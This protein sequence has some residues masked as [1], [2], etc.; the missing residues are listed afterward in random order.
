MKK[1][2][3]LS[4][5]TAAL[6]L[7][8]VSSIRHANVEKEEMN[9][10]IIVRLKSGV[11]N[12][13]S[14]VVI[15]EQNA[16]ISQIREYVTTS[17]EVGER[18]TSLVNA[19]T[20]KVPA[21]RVSQIK[22]LPAVKHVDYNVMHDVKYM[23][24]ELVRVNRSS[25]HVDTEKTNIS[26]G[27]MNK[28]EGT[29]D[30][31][32]VLIAIL[33]TGYL[34][35]GKLYDET[36]KTVLQ[37][38]VTHKAY[39]ALADDVKLHDTEESINAK[40]AAD[41]G[42]HGK[43][44]ATHSVY[45][46][47]KVP[48]FYDYGGTVTEIGKTAEDYDVFEQNQEHGN[49]VASTAAGNDPLYK[50]IAPKAQLAL[51]KVF[52]H[53][54]PTLKDIADGESESFGAYDEAI[55]KA[56]EDCKTLGV[57]IISMSLGSSLDDFDSDSTVQTALKALQ[58]GGTFVN[59][60]AGNDGK[61]TFNGSPYEYWT[62][63][64]A[65][66]G[67]LS[68][69]SNNEGAMTI[70]AAQADKE[71]YESAFLVDGHMV[72]YRDQI[73][74][75]EGKDADYKVERRLTDL[76]EGGQDSFAWEKIPNLG[77][78][79][80]Y[81]GIDVN[82]KIA[83]VDRGEL[84]FAEKIS[85]ATSKGAIAV[86]IIDND[87]TN[88]N[89]NV[90]MALSGANPTVPVI[91]LLY[92]D[93]DI[94]V[95]AVNHTS[96]VIANE[97]ADNPTARKMTD[98]SSDGPTYD[99][100]LKPEISAPGQSILGGV[101]DG[102]DSYEY[103]DGTSMATPNFSGAMA[104][105]LSKDPANAEYRQSI[106]NRIMSTADPMVEVDNNK[107]FASV[108]RQGAGMV[109]INGAL[110]SEVYLDGAT[111]ST[112][113][114]KA[115]I[116]LGNSEKIKNGTVALSFTSVNEGEAVEYSATTYVYRPDITQVNKER[117]SDVMGV[118]L[119]AIYNKQIAKVTNNVTVA[120]G[121][122][123]VSLPD[124]AIPQDELTAINAKFE[125]GCYIEGF[126]ILEA[127]GKETINI[128]FLGYYGDLSALSPVEPFKFERDNTKVYASDILN[129][130]VREWGGSTEADF[131]SDWVSGYYSSFNAIDTSSYLL[132]EKA[133]TDLTG[134][135]TKKLQQVG[136]NPYNGEVSPDDIYMGNNGASNTMI[137]SQFV[138]R[139]VANNTITLKNKATNKT[140]LT[141]H[142][143]DA[144]FGA[145]EDENEVEYQWP[146]YK[147]H[148]VAQQLWSNKLYAHRAYTIIPLYDNIYDKNAKEGEQYSVGELFPDG[149]YEM[150]F[151]YSLT[152]GTVFTKTYTLH[153]DSKAPQI[154]SREKVT[155]D[156]TDYLRFYFDEEKLG[157]ISVN[158]VRKA[159]KQDENGYY[160]DVKISDYAE[161][162]KLLIKSYDY[163]GAVTTSLTYVNDV[164]QII[165]SN[166]NLV[167]SMEFNA[168]LVNGNGELTLS[169][170]I[171]KDGKEAKL[172]GPISV[173]FKLPEGVE[174]D[175]SKF[176]I[177]LPDGK[178][179]DGEVCNGYVTLVLPEGV[180]SVTVKYADPKETPEE[181]AK[182]KGCG[183]SLIAGSAILSI[184]AALGASLLLFKKRKED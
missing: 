79:E 110:T 150:K 77:A 85:N 71:F 120:A 31:E 34:L 156:G 155:V 109:D 53:Y 39:T 13:N 143:Y 69:Y 26:A 42:F 20:L 76:L 100:R 2:A 171:L 28:P 19:F 8:G 16:V 67:I 121:T 14:D 7:G 27:T 25:I 178:D 137:I 35:D 24:P 113:S 175:V 9:A 86:G 6:A 43:P 102:E 144:L 33:D 130:T 93:R 64:M 50:G 45:W 41:K 88:T 136:L 47:N 122:N 37:E 89:F 95:N 138:L 111:G 70:A 51:M 142:M 29:K 82:G 125:S 151:S 107:I 18:F 124:L 112:L 1:L 108:R 149:E 73:V 46:N 99:L 98:F 162:N 106:N 17:I 92:K 181:P 134:S 141:D 10:N 167:G 166:D 160:Y 174:V 129:S 55:L 117:F 44:D 40:I 11:G 21:G 104:V 87:P 131:A 30:G 119:Q 103:M 126:V 164:N 54:T 158:S 128:P 169:L 60:A 177:T 139:S 182:K 3:L 148:I 180:T 168:N 72:A 58:A 96:K 91:M 57:D 163:A 152:D 38:H 114:G 179:I 66:T 101:I 154:T 90:R 15:R 65:E 118:D 147:S 80:D 4:L 56:F 49:H 68:S 140:V 116:E 170:S 165:V 22:S 145:K 173:M 176:A 127:A 133:L 59:V 135:N 63:N 36:G 123:V 32:G 61:N 81:E 161:K 84:T 115:K 183:G 157:Y 52:T 74:N 94:F 184:T 12:K 62:T 75:E 146:L 153:I 159:I 5:A 97:E 78:L 83:I 172:K 105:I 48:F 132:N 23:E